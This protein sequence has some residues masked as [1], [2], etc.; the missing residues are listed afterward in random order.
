MRLLLFIALIHGRLAQ[1]SPIVETLQ[2]TK[3]SPSLEWAGSAAVL[4]TES[5]ESLRFALSHLATATLVFILVSFA[6]L[7]LFLFHF[8]RKKTHEIYFSFL[9]FGGAVLAGLGSPL[10]VSFFIGI[11]FRLD[12]NLQRY[13]VGGILT[14]ILLTLYLFMDEAFFRRSKRGLRLSLVTLNAALFIGQD[15]IPPLVLIFSVYLQGSILF[16]LGLNLLKRKGAPFEL[17]LCLL[18]LAV[19]VFEAA[20][21]PFDIS[22]SEPSRT[23]Y[24]VLILA[25]GRLLKLKTLFAFDVRL[26]R[27]VAPLENYAHLPSLADSGEPADDQAIVSEL[28]NRSLETFSVYMDTLHNGLTQLSS[29]ILKTLLRDDGRLRTLYIQSKTLEESARLLGFR[30]LSRKLSC[31]ANSL[32]R[33]LQDLDSQWNP[34]I[35]NQEIDTVRK[36]AQQY[37]RLNSKILGRRLEH[38]SKVLFN[39]DIKHL[40]DADP[41]LLLPELKQAIDLAKAAFEHMAWSPLTATVEHVVREAAW[42][43]KGKNILDLSFEDHSAALYA[44]KF[45]DLAPIR[46]I[47][48]HLVDNTKQHGME[49]AHERLLKNKSGA[50]HI[51]ITLTPIGE[52]L[53]LRFHDDGRGLG[54]LQLREWAHDDRLL[55]RDKGGNLQY[56]AKLLLVKAWRAPR[57]LTR[58]L[59]SAEHLKSRIEIALYPEHIQGGHCPFAIELHLPLNRLR[60]PTRP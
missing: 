25:L 37:L 52:S 8:D 17:G 12:P 43:S 38:A 45:E 21:L 50:T 35:L 3:T 31:L 28:N 60:M 47:V 57:G 34:L 53:V 32:M 20:R 14:L 54:I 16:L 7:F 13:G 4:P 29:T 46:N 19:G 55:D 10:Q 39:K 15:R 41:S 18:L 22:P 36:V 11:P 23:P 44:L 9:C 59:E 5:V 30:V 27:P 26:T 56:Y 2:N 6:L 48:T 40:E 24:F 51:R 1:A 49:T 42:I 33:L 58:C